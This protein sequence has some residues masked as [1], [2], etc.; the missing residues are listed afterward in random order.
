[1]IGAGVLLMLKKEVEWIQPSSQKGIERNSVPM[2]SMQTLFDAAL[3]VETAGFTSWEEL[4]RADL[5]PGKGIIKFVSATNWE[6]QVDTHTAEVLQVAQ[7]RS[8]VIEAI[9][10]GSYFADWIKLGIF[11]PAGIGLFILWVTGIYLFGL[12]EYKKIKNRK[13]SNTV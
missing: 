7:R 4:E 8:D 1:M 5:K 3:T 12:T 11:L 10:D 13:R 6:V 2:A 9:H